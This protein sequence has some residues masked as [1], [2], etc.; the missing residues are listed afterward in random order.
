M[1]ASILS[2]IYSQLA[3]MSVSYTDRANATATPTV[4]SLATIPGNIQ[5]AH[6][7]CRLLLPIGQ[8]GG[9]NNMRILQG[10]GVV[11]SWA[12]TDLFLLMT[13]AQQE[14]LHAQ[15][16]VLISYVMAYARALAAQF[17][18]LSAPSTETRT[19]SAN[20]LPNI[21]EYPGGSGVLFYGVK[22]DL[23][24]EELI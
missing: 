15:A 22:V 24:V 3:S 13:A 12:I 1:T 20:I 23:I 21:W 5:T 2:T 4:Y 7:P 6:L 11:A 14:G 17:R 18:F 9:T 10:A 8:G 19:I 16:P